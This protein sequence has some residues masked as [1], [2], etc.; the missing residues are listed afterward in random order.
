MD[1]AFK[2]RKVRKI[3]ED[4]AEARK[5]LGADAAKKLQLRLSQLHAAANLDELPSGKPHP[6]HNEY[7]GCFGITL[8]GGIRLVIRPANDPLPLRPGGDLDRARVT[9]VTIVYIG[10]YHD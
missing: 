9:I 2:D 5:K 8:H 1:I 10:D 6:L 7:E 4:A 3:C